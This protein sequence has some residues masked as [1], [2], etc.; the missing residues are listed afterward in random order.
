MNRVHCPVC[1]VP[2]VPRGEIVVGGELICTVCGARLEVLDVEPEVAARRFSEEPPAEITGRIDRFA[3]Q[4]GFVFSEDK[5]LVVE[6]LLQKESMF[7]DFYCPCRIENI[8]E[9]ICPCLE[10][11]SGSVRRDGHC[12]CGLFWTPGAL[13]GA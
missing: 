3:E 12:R 4:R 8:E 5:D 6:G 7:G 2:F 10:T 11:R 9:N 13:E 1:K